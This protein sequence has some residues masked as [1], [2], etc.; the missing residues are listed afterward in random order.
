[1]EIERLEKEIADQRAE[2]KTSDETI[3]AEINRIKN[4]I[5]FTVGG[6]A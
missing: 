2:T 3:T 1:M 4:L 6:N 5:N